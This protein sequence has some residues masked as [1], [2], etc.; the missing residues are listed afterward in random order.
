LTTTLEQDIHH[1]PSI[2]LENLGSVGILRVLETVTKQGTINI[3]HL[4]R[5]T[6]LNQ[7]GVDSHIRK[8]VELGLVEEQWYGK[9]RMIRP[10]F[11]S[12]SVVFKKGMGVKVVRTQIT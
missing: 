8:L 10:T 12:L 5:K 11:D 3:S 4:S 6:G 7:P 1:S 9:L 2:K